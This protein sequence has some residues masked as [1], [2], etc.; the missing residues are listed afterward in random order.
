MGAGVIVERSDADERGDLLAWK[1][2]EFWQFGHQNTSGCGADALDGLQ[3]GTS[4][5]QFIAEIDGLGDSGF[6]RGDLSLQMIKR[7]FDGLT[8]EIEGDVLALVAA[9]DALFDELAAAI[10]ELSQFLLEIRGFFAQSNRNH[11]SEERQDASIDAIG[12]GED[13]KRFGEVTHGPWIDHGD[14]KLCV[15]HAVEHIAFVSAGGF[16]DDA[17]G[18]GISEPGDQLH[19]AIGR[20]LKLM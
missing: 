2:P 4:L 17:G 15:E 5:P 10:D 6:N 9:G 7:A 14:G 18:C 1:G 11:S 8:N 19:D 3:C 12:L 16:N 13:A 20:I